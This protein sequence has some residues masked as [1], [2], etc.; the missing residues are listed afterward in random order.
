MQQNGLGAGILHGHGGLKN[1][2]NNILK[3]KSCINHEIS[4]RLSLKTNSNTR[5]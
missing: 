2:K 1:F 5:E 4:K 3:K